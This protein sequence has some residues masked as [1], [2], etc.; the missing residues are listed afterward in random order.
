VQ[1]APAPHILPV[2]QV[3]PW[4]SQVVPPQS[5]SVS[6]PFCTVSVQVGAEQVPL[7]EQTLSIQS[8]PT[9]HVL[10][11]AH[12][13]QTEPPQS[14]SVSVPSFWPS[15]QPAGTQSPTPSQTEP[16]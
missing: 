3:W 2:A 11:S 6:V 10:P 14:M 16:P 7:A 9:R 5:T 12:G 15:L 1:S 13:G 8:P 4:L